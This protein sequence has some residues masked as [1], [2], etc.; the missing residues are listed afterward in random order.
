MTTQTVDP[1]EDSVHGVVSTTIALTMQ[2]ERIQEEKRELRRK[3]EEL[4]RRENQL[5]REYQMCIDRLTPS[6]ISTTRL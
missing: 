1:N 6:Y 3:L 2:L 5:M 4:C